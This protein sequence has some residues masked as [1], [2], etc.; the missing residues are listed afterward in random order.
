MNVA[1]GICV[2]QCA[3]AKATSYLGQHQSR[4]LSGHNVK[5]IVCNCRRH[6]E[7][8]LGRM[9]VD[10]L[11]GQCAHHGE[12]TPM[13]VRCHPPAVNVIAMF[14]CWSHDVHVHFDHQEALHVVEIATPFRCCYL[15]AC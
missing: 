11:A 10:G 6:S 9:T 3:L 13:V 5:T 14:V 15:V 1:P 8:Q 2:S 7:V 4:H 12:V